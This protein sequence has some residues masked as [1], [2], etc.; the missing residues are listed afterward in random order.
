MNS[1]HCGHRVKKSLSTRTHSCS[2]C[3]IEICRDTNAAITAI[4]R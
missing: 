3:G 4:F 1:S 2:S